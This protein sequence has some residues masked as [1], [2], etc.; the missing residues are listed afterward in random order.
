MSGLIKVESTA[1]NKARSKNAEHFTSS[2]V[3]FTLNFPET[4]ISTKISLLNH[5]LLKRNI[6]KVVAKIE[7]RELNGQLFDT[8]KMEISDPRSYDFNPLRDTNKNFAG[9]TYIFFESNENLAVPFCAVVASIEATSS[10]CAVHTYG[11][12]LE[13]CELGGKLDASKTIES[14]WTLRNKNNSNSFAVF[15]NGRESVNINI[16]LEV[17]N[18]QGEHQLKEWNESLLPWAI[19]PD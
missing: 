8:Y 6:E 11:R 12:V 17:T 19:L 15:H 18:A 10:I 3:F 13:E 9:S 14:G 5:F 1:E 7:L 2:A 4:N 16:A